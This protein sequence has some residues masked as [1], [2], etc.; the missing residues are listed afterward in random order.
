MSL[1]I[2][3][4]SMFTSALQLNCGKAEDGVAEGNGSGEHKFNDGSVMPTNSCPPVYQINN[5]RD[6]REMVVDFL[7][8]PTTNGG[9]PS[10]ETPSNTF[11]IE[12]Q[13]KAFQSF[14]K[15]A[16]MEDH[17]GEGGTSLGGPSWSYE[18][19][20]KQNYQIQPHEPNLAKLCIEFAK[21]ED[22]FGALCRDLS[23]D[24]IALSYWDSCIDSDSLI[25]YELSDDTKRKEWLDDWLSFMHRIAAEAVARHGAMAMAPSGRASPSSVDSEAP[26]KRARLAEPSTDTPV[27]TGGQMKITTRKPEGQQ[28]D[29]SMVVSMEINGVTYQGVLFALEEGS[30][31]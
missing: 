7:T 28:A 4:S 13:Q 8:L 10:P 29:N 30:K 15:D 1:R 6:R 18:E 11:D 5:I 27:N 16:K 9:T 14:R 24:P 31:T 21:P 2:D 25:L 3:D 17:H 12:A 19:Q 23:R 20:F 26:A 22:W